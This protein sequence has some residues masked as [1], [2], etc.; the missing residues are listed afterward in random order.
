MRC[1]VAL[2]PRA[3]ETL[4]RMFLVVL[5]TSSE[6]R[7]VIPFM[8][9]C[10]RTS[11]LG[12]GQDTPAHSDE[13]AVGEEARAWWRPGGPSPAERGGRVCSEKSEHSK[14]P[15]R[16]SGASGR[17]RWL[18]TARTVI[19]CSLFYICDSDHFM[20]KFFDFTFEFVCIYSWMHIS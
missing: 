3:R 18:G 8:S 5:V 9:L 4:I 17:A 16:R 1:A 13:V 2:V 14:I 11:T 7:D 20:F 6:A 10:G 19:L 15:R 12:E